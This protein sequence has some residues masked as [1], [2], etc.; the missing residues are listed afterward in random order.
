MLEENNHLELLKLIFQKVREAGLKLNL[1]KCA[2][3]RDIYN[4]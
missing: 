3:S 1:S 2:F 4:I